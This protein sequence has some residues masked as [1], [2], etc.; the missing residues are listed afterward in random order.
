MLD[1]TLGNSRYWR[2]KAEAGAR[3]TEKRQAMTDE[4]R[5]E[6]YPWSDKNLDVRK[7]MLLNFDDVKL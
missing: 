6:D 2:L 7:D 5:M 3:V 4:E 1:G